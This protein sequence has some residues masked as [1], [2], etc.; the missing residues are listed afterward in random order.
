MED[1]LWTVDHW[2]TDHGPRAQRSEIGAARPSPPSRGDFKE[3]CP[4]MGPNAAQYS[5]GLGLGTTAG[6]GQRRYS[7]LLVHY[8]ATTPS[9]HERK[10]REIQLTA[11]PI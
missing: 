1:G 4:G 7:R 6:K 8:T 3:R 10:K 2:T 11:I 9:L 5:M